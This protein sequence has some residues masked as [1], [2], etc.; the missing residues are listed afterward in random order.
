MYYRSMKKLTERE[1][2]ELFHLLFLEYLGRTINKSLYALKGGCNLRFFLLSPRYSEDMDLDIQTIGRGTL[3]NKVERLLKNIAF[4]VALKARGITILD[5]STPKQTDTTQRW[6]I[7]IEVAGASETHTK[8]EF[9][10]R[11]MSAKTLYE[12]ISRELAMTY[13]LSPIMA[14]HYTKEEAFLQ[15]IHA[16]AGRSVTQARDLFDLY[17]LV[18]CGVNPSQVSVPQK[19]LSQAAS[20]AF[21][22]SYEDYC[23]LVVAYLPHDQQ[24]VYQEETLWDQIVLNISEV[25]GS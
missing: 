3:Q 15:K 9:S 6:K 5:H 1:A 11:K 14:N 10:R 4:N 25:L 8:I 12:P 7:A 21:N 24:K 13:Q 2:T 23:S 16:L 20:V 18:Q 17:H 22:V 19:V